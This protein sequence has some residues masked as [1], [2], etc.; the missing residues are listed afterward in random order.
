[1]NEDRQVNC[2]EA[3]A[4]CTFL[5]FRGSTFIKN[6]ALEAGGAVLA[7]D[8]NAIRG[9]CIYPDQQ[10]PL[11]FMNRPQFEAL[12]VLNSK[13]SVCRSWT[14]N[15]AG[16][17]GSDLASYGRGVRKV[18]RFEES[19][20]E[21]KVEGNIYFLQNH[22]SGSQLPSLFLTVVDQAGQGPAIGAGNETLVARMQSPDGLFTGSVRVLLEKGV[23][24]FSGISG[25]Q[26]PGIYEVRVVF[27]SR[28]IPAFTILVE[29]RNCMIGEAA[30]ANGTVCQRCSGDSF[31][32]FPDRENAVC[33]ACPEHARCDGTVMY[34][35]KR[36]WHSAPCSSHIQECLTREACDD[37]GR[38]ERLR[39]IGRSIRSCNF[40]ELFIEEYRKA[41]CKKV[42]SDPALQESPVEF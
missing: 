21:E 27:S 10:D 12:A 13:E 42:R 11:V 24:N 5:A 15:K 9:N 6:E 22:L 19:G 2:S 28:T 7:S 25:Y 18:I 35:R 1:M 39:N 34:P 36:H 14:G 16:D 33:E 8:L 3:G 17:Y 20:D 29:V 23:G 38:D 37:E 40:T 31:N 30:V 41:E 26:E 4:N 32:F